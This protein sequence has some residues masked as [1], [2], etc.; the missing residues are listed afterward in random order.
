MLVFFC[1]AIPPVWVL[2]GP[3]SRKGV[4]PGTRR[5]PR[6]D[7]VGLELGQDHEHSRRGPG[8]Q[9]EAQHGCAPGAPSVRAARAT[10]HRSRRPSSHV[11]CAAWLPRAPS[12]VSSW[13]SAPQI[14]VI[15]PSRAH[16]THRVVPEPERQRILPFPLYA[17]C[18]AV[19]AAGPVCRRPQALPCSERD[20][21]LGGPDVSSSGPAKG[22]DDTGESAGSN[23]PGSRVQASTRHHV[24]NRG[25]VPLPPQ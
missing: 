8:P 24:P 9:L 20:P 14:M 10:G 1:A 23:G 3:T 11:G 19:H 6:T 13:V 15:A 25:R 17:R 16:M 5:R 22:A 2:P 18:L 21:L 7:P 4:S 12:A